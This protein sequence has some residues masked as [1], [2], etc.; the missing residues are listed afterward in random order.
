MQLPDIVNFNAH[1]IDDYVFTEQCKQHLNDSG[2][3]VLKNFLST[4]AIQLIVDEALAEQHLAFYTNTQHNV[5][6]K[7]SDPSYT[8]NHVRNRLI[9][10]SKG[11]ITDDQI[12]KHSVL[13]QLYN[14]ALELGW[15]FDESSFAITLLLQAPEAGG[16]FEYI[17]DMR[18]ADAGDM[19][20]SGV[21][22]VLDGHVDIKTLSA[23]AGTLTLFRGRNA[24]HRVTPV[25]GN[26]TRILAVLAYNSAANVALSEAARMTFYGR[27]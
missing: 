10:S 8:D 7:K 13:K 15:H 19:N 25:T 18:D 2:S 6:L 16:Q 23:T 26:T 14:S 11:C 22:K 20:F 21:T 12:P 27:T 4:A 17:E 3:L 9:T 1:P 5:Y 24:M